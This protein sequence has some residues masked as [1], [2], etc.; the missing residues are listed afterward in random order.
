VPRPTLHTTVKT[1]LSDAHYLGDY[2]GIILDPTW[3]ALLGFKDGPAPGREEEKEH[4]LVQTISRVLTTR[5]TELETFLLAGGVLVAKVQP[6]AGLYAK[7]MYTS[8]VTARVDTIGWLAEPIPPMGYA[9]EL[10]SW[11]FIEGSGAEIVIREPGHVLESLILSA[12][13][14]T[15]RL[16]PELFIRKGTT[17]LATTRIGDPIAAEIAVGNGLVLL[18]PSGVDED[19]LRAD[20]EE[21]LAMRERYRSS[22]LLP[23]EMVVIEEDKALLDE[24]RSKREA[25]RQQAE[26]LAKIRA[27]VMSTVDVK[28]A[29][30]YYESGT[31]AARPVKQAMVDLYKLVELLEGFFGG[32]EGGL[33]SG[34]A[35]PKT[36]FK[37][38]KKLA[39]QKELDFRH[40]TSGEIVGA[41][42]AEVEQAREDA[43][44]LVQKFVERCSAQEIQ[45]RTTEV[46]EHP[47]DG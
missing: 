25:L 16:A 35:V 7:N 33:A 39:N 29:I 13:K 45:R 34:L 22:W 24:T 4:G 47:R 2:E 27:S 30:A 8:A 46:A 32:S 15:A 42:V 10:R 12:T 40:A 43:R 36:R 6:T 31:S 9:M 21:I 18:I 41:D 20:F 26:G 14:Y 23:E 19:Q 44:V 11:P 28:R 38:I 1:P 5:A 17:V 3:E 37:H